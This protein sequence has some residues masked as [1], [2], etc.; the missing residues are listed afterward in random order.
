MPIPTE[1]SVKTR[2]ATHG[3]RRSKVVD[4]TGDPKPEDLASRDDDQGTSTEA[5]S[6]LRTPYTLEQDEDG[7]WCVRARVRPGVDAFGVGAT[8][9]AALDHVRAVLGLLLSVTGDDQGDSGYR[10]GRRDHGQVV[11][12]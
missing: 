2:Q 12:R 6:V 5:D 3:C 8:R 10:P 4:Y 7:F 1:F 11:M 9:E